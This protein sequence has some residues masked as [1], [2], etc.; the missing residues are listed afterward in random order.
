[1][2]PKMRKTK[3]KQSQVHFTTESIF[4]KTPIVTSGKNTKSP[5]KLKSNKLS[6][7]NLKPNSPSS[8]NKS[9]AKQKK[10]IVSEH[11]QRTAI[12]S[13]SKKP[14]HTISTRVAK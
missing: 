10:V 14:I 9:K 12:H 8:K 4:K 13:T 1:M 5:A 7:T 3:Q 2:I 11:E 6:G